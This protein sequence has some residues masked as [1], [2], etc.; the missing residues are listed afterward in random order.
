M[1]E[2]ENS[3]FGGVQLGRGG[4]DGGHQSTVATIRHA[5]TSNPAATSRPETGTARVSRYDI[6]FVEIYASARKH[7][8]GDSDIHHAVEHAAA[9]GEQDDGKVLYLGPDR[10]GN[11]LRSCR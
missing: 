5:A 6:R 2:E 8:I 10:A 3:R 4:L 7:G 9:V 1:T 11:C